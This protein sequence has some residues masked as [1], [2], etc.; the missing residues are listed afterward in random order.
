MAFNIKNE[1]TI[2]QAR[3]IAAQ[4]GESIAAV[5]DAAVAD[6]ARRLGV[7]DEELVARVLRRT[8]R[9]A[10]RLSPEAKAISIDEYLYDEQGMPK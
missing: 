4:T 8:S 5:I 2:E 9:I 7:V 6:H 1:A 3:R 10:A